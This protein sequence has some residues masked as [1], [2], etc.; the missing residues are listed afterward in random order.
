MFFM[1]PI[2]NLLEGEHCGGVGVGGGATHLA[3]LKANGQVGY[4]LLI[5]RDNC[6][7]NLCIYDN[8]VCNGINVSGLEVEMREP[9][10]LGGG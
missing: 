6:E 2:I 4:T 10:G 8:S 7:T 9:T 5:C 1:D 3:H